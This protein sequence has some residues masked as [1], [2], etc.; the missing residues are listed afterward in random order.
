MLFYCCNHQYTFKPFLQLNMQLIHQLEKRK[1][2]AATCERFDNARRLKAAIKEMEIIGQSV[3]ALEMEKKALV[4]KQDYEGAK[5]KKSEIEDVKDEAYR[6]WAI[7]ELLEM[8]S[9]SLRRSALDR[10]SKPQ[11]VALPP[12]AMQKYKPCSP[13]SDEGQAEVKAT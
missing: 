9:P 6:K 8:P 7:A 4:T 5:E 1:Y 13:T 2:E 12:P 11:P 10:G 3:A